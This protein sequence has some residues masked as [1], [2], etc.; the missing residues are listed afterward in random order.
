LNTFSQDSR[1]YLAARPRYPED[2]Y[3]WIALNSPALTT[4]WDCACGNGQ[5]AIGLAR[6]FHRVEATDLSEQQIMAAK[7]HDRVYYR[8][9]AAERIIFPADSFDCV[10]VAQALHWF[11]FA[12]WW[13]E[14]GRVAKTGALFVAWGYDWMECPEEIDK[15]I[16]L[17]FRE[18][19]APF[20]PPQNKILWDGYQESDIRFSLPKISMPEFAIQVRWTIHQLIGY[21]KTWSAYK[22]SCQN[23]AATRKMKTLLSTIEYAQAEVP[24]RMPL[25]AIC[26]RV[27]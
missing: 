15:T 11:D 17:P 2:L 13:Q 5:A 24:V 25:K 9:M 8:V 21:M 12:T 3:A 19:I 20:W 27:Q 16:V 10:V 7:A 22:L 23:L 1:E 18:I 6:F 4:A 14:L 26:G